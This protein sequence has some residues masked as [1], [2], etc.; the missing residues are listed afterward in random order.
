MP[1]LRPSPASVSTPDLHR[2]GV[3]QADS[4]FKS[5]YKTGRLVQKPAV[6]ASRYPGALSFPSRPV[7]SAT[8]VLLHAAPPNNPA[9][10]AH[11]RNAA[12]RGL[13]ASQRGKWSLAAGP[14]ASGPRGGAPISRRPISTREAGWDRACRLRGGGYGGHARGGRAPVLQAELAEGSE[15]RWPRQSWSR[16]R[17]MNGIAGTSHIDSRE[18]VLKLGESFEKQPRCAFHTVRCE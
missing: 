16:R 4:P 12:C 11:L 17:M 15:R 9:P 1:R 14:G 3:E 2:K 8:S 10:T 7:R 13:R 6:R 18:R 5:S